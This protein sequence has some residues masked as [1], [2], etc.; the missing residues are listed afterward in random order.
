MVETNFVAHLLTF[1]SDLIFTNDKS[2]IDYIVQIQHQ[3]PINCISTFNNSIS[4]YFKNKYQCSNIS[5]DFETDAIKNNNNYFVHIFHL[6]C[7]KLWSCFSDL[8]YSL[9]HIH[10]LLFVDH[11]KQDRSSNIQ[12]SLICSISG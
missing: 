4:V 8:L 12:P 9:H 7:D 6:T 10:L 11:I 2:K 3:S 1:L 5:L